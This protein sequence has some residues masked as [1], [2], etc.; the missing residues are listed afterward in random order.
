MNENPIVL[1]VRTGVI[2]SI[3][4]EE[5]KYITDAT[6]RELEL[7]NWP[8]DKKHKLIESMNQNWQL[9]CRIVRPMAAKR[10]VS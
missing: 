9:E 10:D 2:L 3:Y 5:F 7:K 8:R 4:Y 1:P 6:A